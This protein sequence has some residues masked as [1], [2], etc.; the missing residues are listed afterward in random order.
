MKRNLAFP[1]VLFSILIFAEIVSYLAVRNFYVEQKSNLKLFNWIWWTSTATL[2][3]MVFTTRS[4]ESN[5]AKN[6]LVNIFMFILILKLFIGLVFFISSLVQFIQTFFLTEKL[7]AENSLGRRKFASKI[8]IGAA[9]IPFS[10]M[11]WGIF[12]TAYDFK[13]H[14]VK[15]NSAKIPS[16]FNGLRIVQL[17]DIHTGSLQG[18]KQLQKAV[19]LVKGLKPDVVV[20]TGDLVNNQSN[21]AFPYLKILKQIEAPMG[22]YSVLGNHDYGDY[23]S[24]ESEHAKEKN[25]QEMFQIHQNLNWKL[26]MNEHVSLE[27]NGESIALI[28]IE[29]WGANLNFK[30]YGDLNKAYQGSENHPYKILLSHDPSH[31]STEVKEFY[32]DIDLTL[33]GHTHGF[34]FGVEIPGFKWSPSQYIYPQWSGLYKNNEQLLYVNRGLGCLGYM[35]RI[36][37][38]PEITLIELNA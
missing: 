38:K 34:Q 2:Y 4:L 20:F 22:V 32:K 25:M 26:L 19:D 29:N 10:S 17:S 15:V 14:E 28:G 12:K 9:A 3:L 30:K 36:G 7:S 18:E 33:S 35:G 27:K 13:I 6:V 24:W 37:I 11:L 16:S 1:I 31:W 23:N 21:E 8:A 5:F